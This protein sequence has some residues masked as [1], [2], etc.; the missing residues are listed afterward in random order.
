MATASPTT[1]IR[2]SQQSPVVTVELRQ[3]VQVNFRSKLGTRICKDGK[4]SAGDGGAELF[5]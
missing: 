3:R 2:S 1:V 4:L 5:P